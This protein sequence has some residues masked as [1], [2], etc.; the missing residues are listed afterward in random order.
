MH[1]RRLQAIILIAP[2]CW[3]WA[4]QAID[5][6]AVV[7][8]LQLVPYGFAKSWRESGHSQSAATIV[9]QNLG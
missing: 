2:R 5:E 7:R 6:A 3:W 9:T 1:T 8:I 4:V